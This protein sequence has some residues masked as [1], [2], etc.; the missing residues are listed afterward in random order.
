MAYCFLG[1]NYGQIGKFA[2]A[3]EAENQTKAIGEAISDPRIQTYA[4]FIT[5]W[6]TVMIGDWDTA[7]AVCQHGLHISPDPTSTAYSSAFLGYAYLEKGDAEQALPLLEEAAQR[8][9]QF[10][11]APF[12]GL[13]TVFLA[14]SH[15][16]T[17]QLESTHQ[18]AKRALDTTT[19][20]RYGYGVGWA[21]HTLGRIAQARV[22]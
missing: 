22:I 10:Q 14:E 19:Q 21:Q 9:Q 7:V 5:G 13:F 8:F 20:A 3:L 15:R 17:E 6:F 16:C 11:F 18:L 2:L 12:E 1:Y 4:A